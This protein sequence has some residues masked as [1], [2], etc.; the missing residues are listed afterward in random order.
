MEQQTVIRANAK[1]GAG[2]P[3]GAVSS[4]FEAGAHAKPP[5]RQYDRID[6]GAIKIESGVPVP[7]TS[8]G[9]ASPWPVV[10]A[11]MKPGDMVRLTHRQ[12][13]S[14]VSWGK[15]HTA[16][17]TRRKLGDDSVGVWRTG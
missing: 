9:K 14:F 1:P 15:K 16:A 11:R 5:T 4:V 17:L 3:T 2:K 7:E 12:A 6:A 13:T 8:P 10:Y